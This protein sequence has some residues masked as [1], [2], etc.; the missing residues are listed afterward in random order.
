MRVPSIAGYRF[1]VVSCQMNYH[2]F[3]VV[4]SSVRQLTDFGEYVIVQF[5]TGKNPWYS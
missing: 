5:T 1:S 3:T 4:V 2:D